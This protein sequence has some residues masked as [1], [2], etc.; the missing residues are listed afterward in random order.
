MRKPKKN[1]NWRSFD[2]GPKPR[3]KSYDPLP[4]DWTPLNGAKTSS[5]YMAETHG[6]GRIENVP[7]F[8]TRRALTSGLS[9][10]RSAAS[11]GLIK[12]A[13]QEN[14]EL[15]P[16]PNSTSIP[17][18]SICQIHITWPNGVREKGTAWFAGPSLLVT[19]G[20]CVWDHENGGGA[21]EITV[22]P[23]INGSNPPFGAWPAKT[24][25]AHDNWIDNADPH[26]DY[27]FI[28]LEDPTIGK[29][30]GWFGFSVSPSN[31]PSL[32]VNIAGY[33][34]NKPDG[35][36]WFNSGRIVDQDDAFLTYMLETEGG[37]SGSP[38]FWYSDDKRIVLAVHAYSGPTGNQGLRVTDEMYDRIVELRGF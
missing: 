19:A 22:V 17:W 10:G 21:S 36:M 14:D 11:L 29:Q 15:A 37:E 8:D 13:A 16:V 12:Q 9:I 35:T 32:L 1:G 4:L 27:G 18:R 23:G 5:S 24:F 6:G 34:A 38:C 28:Q 30:L 3:N 33:P 20:H 2:I 31:L 7:G 25:D 26:F